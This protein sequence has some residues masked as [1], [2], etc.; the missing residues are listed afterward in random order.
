MEQ[1]VQ[2]LKAMIA[3]MQQAGRYDL[4]LQAIG[5]PL[6]HQLLIEAAKCNLSVLTITADYRFILKNTNTEIELSPIAKALYILFIN[7][8]EGIAFKELPDFRDELMEIY[9]KVTNRVSS[10][11]VRHTIERI[12]N[13]LDNAINEHCSRI[14]AAFAAHLDQY[15]LS[16]YVI[17]S[18]APRQFKSSKRIWFER[19]KTITLPRNLVEFASTPAQHSAS[20]DSACC[21]K[22]T[23]DSG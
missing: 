15:S 20:Q 18:H 21:Q 6:L 17:A 5:T 12:T 23:G 4:L 13:P 3:E 11:A 9:L 1:N 14:K 22:A 16:Y 2:Q 10:D 7:H 19:K 8:E